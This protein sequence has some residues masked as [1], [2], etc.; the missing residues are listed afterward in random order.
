MKILL[1]YPDFIRD[2]SPPPPLGIVL[3]GTILRKNGFDVDLMAGNGVKDW[4]SVRQIIEDSR[5]DVLGISI[6]TPIAGVGF[7]MARIA[8]E[9]LPS[10][11][12]IMG[13][14][15]ATILPLETIGNEH[16]DVVCLGE[17][18]ETL[19][20]LINNLDNLENVK[21]IYYKKDGKIKM[22]PP[23]PYIEDLDS[24]PFPDWSLLPHLESYFD[25][26]M[27]RKLPMLLSRG[28]LFN[29]NFCQPTLRNIFGKKV[30]FRSV[31]NVVDEMEYL[32]SNYHVDI[33]RF[34]DDTFTSNKKWALGICD[35]IVR[36]DMKVSWEVNSRVDTITEEMLMRMKESGCTEL[37]F[38]VESGSEYIR[39]SVLGKG[40]SDDSIKKAFAQCRQARIKTNAFVM[41]G[42]P[43]E[44][45]ETL[46]QTLKL[47]KEIKPYHIYPSRTTPLPGTLLWEKAREEGSLNIDTY[48]D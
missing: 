23:R 19:I 37:S 21:G 32:A 4:D 42:S 6:L 13:G 12:V 22:N 1:A 7:E 27:V 41:L 48:N 5:P 39:N 43:G 2:E 9:I 47:L 36:R 44:T 15:H 20:Q 38:G 10:V 26:A 45:K 8:K 18:D 34:E 29:C 17:G 33:F 14:A 31:T 30:R 25:S 40:I 3:L 35:E 24:L 11:F 28:C 46:R 16:V